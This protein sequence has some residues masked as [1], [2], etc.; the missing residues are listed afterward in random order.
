LKSFFVTPP[1]FLVRGS[2]RSHLTLKKSVGSKRGF[3][4]D[5]LPK[6]QT[7]LTVFVKD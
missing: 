3:Q 6:R 1:F 2:L 4:A 7:F 5:M